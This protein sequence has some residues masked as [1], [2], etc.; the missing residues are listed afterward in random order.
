MNASRQSN[1][2]MITLFVVM[3]VGCVI[4]F[5]SA[6]DGPNKSKCVAGKVDSKLQTKKVNGDCPRI[7]TNSVTPRRSTWA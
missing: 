5:A 6:V 4:A 2:P 7:D 1:F 3:V